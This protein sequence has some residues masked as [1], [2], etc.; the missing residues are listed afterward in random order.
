MTGPVAFDEFFADAAPRVL[1]RALVLAANRH[2][3]ED[4]VQEAFSE[5]LRRWDRIR[6]YEAPEAWLHLVVRQRLWK[7]SARWR[8]L[9][10]LTAIELDAWPA[11]TGDP[12][13]AVLVESVLSAVA[14]LPRRQRTMLVMHCLQGMK[15]DEIAEE[16]RVRAGT[17]A[18]T[19]F[20]A[21]RALGR[22]LQAVLELADTGPGLEPLFPPTA[23]LAMP[24]QDPIGAVLDAASRWLA[25]RIAEHGPGLDRVRR[26][27]SARVPR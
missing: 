4:A 16:L 23:E 24:D 17:V 22:S 11:T 19:I 2:D 25:G 3:A 21:R 14:E 8:R 1:A 26:N 18:A 5:A 12:E 20:N 6:G 13:Q 15:Y 10:T 7:A 9:S 27:V